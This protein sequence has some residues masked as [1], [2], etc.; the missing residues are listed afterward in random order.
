[1]PGV[2][3]GRAGLIEE[4][5]GG[6]RSGFVAIVGRPNAGKSTLLNRYV[7]QKVAI[8]SPKPQTTRYQT[9]GILTARDAQVI[10]VDT[11]GLTRPYHRLDERM[12]EAVRRA[13]PDADVVLFVA[14]LSAPPTDD[15]RRLGELIAGR[16]CPIL[17]LNKAD[18]APQHEQTARNAAAKHDSELIGSV[19]FIDRKSVV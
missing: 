14:D 19:P 15:D 7:G 3:E 18:L 12:M 2:S 10:F 6:Y 8:V 9:L 5:P 1:M 17:V 11:P 4:A 16:P 13:I